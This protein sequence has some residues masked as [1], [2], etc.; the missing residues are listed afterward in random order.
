MKFEWNGQWE[1]YCDKITDNVI[2]LE[3]YT[4]SETQVKL[5]KPLIQESVKR[6]QF[7]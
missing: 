3:S 6:K 7:Q 4:H 2:K 1:C 5:S